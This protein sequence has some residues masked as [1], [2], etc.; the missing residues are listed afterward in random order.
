[1]DRRFYSANPIIGPECCLTGDEAHHVARVLRASIGDEVILFDNSGYEFLARITAIGKHDVQLVILESK[2]LNRELPAPLHIGVAL[3][4]GERQKWLIE[5][6]V[7]LGVTA[8][9][10]IRA[11]HG[12]AQPT[13]DVLER[14]RRQVIEAAKQ[15]GRNRLMAIHP[16]SSIEEFCQATPATD[17]R[18]IAHPDQSMHMQ[19]QLA[20]R[21]SPSKQATIVVAIG[22]EGGWDEA[23]VDSAIKSG[24]SAVSL[25]QRIVRVETAVCVAAT[26]AATWMEAT[27]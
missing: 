17:V 21:G 20:A 27:E 9:T 11:A 23:E 3:P 5:K 1:M 15:C 4:K 10:P 24:W 16:P 26:I 8:L 19:R 22:P 25:G 6:A 14:L 18:F 12:V 7:E 13:A 2:L